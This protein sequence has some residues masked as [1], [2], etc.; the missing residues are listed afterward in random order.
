MC[1]DSHLFNLR[2]DLNFSKDQLKVI[3]SSRCP[4]K[5][6]IKRLL[7]STLNP[8]DGYTLLKIS[9]QLGRLVSILKEVEDMEDPMALDVEC[10]LCLVPSNDIEAYEDNYLQVKSSLQSLSTGAIYSNGR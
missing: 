1:S 6:S 2:F 9:S 10:E 7:N 4:P 3:N 8:R 5:S